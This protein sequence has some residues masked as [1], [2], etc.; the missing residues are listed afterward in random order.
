M[1]SED[2]ENAL[3]LVITWYKTPNVT[4]VLLITYN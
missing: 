4:P 1:N 3:S 2:V